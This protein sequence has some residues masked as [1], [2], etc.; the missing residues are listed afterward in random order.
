MHDKHV[1]RQHQLPGNSFELNLVAIENKTK[2]LSVTAPTFG[3]VSHDVVKI[4]TQ[5]LHD[6][7][8]RIEIFAYL[9]H[10]QH[11]K[12]GN[13]LSDIVEILHCSM[14][15]HKAVVIEIADIPRSQ[16]KCGIFGL[17]GH[18]FIHLHPQD[19]QSGYHPEA[20]LLRL[21]VFDRSIEW[22]IVPP[23]GLTAGS[24]PHHRRAARQTV[25]QW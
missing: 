5:D 6:F 2:P 18:L 13:D 1:L 17:M 22:H 15:A 10:G 16:Y 11:I 20:R 21:D 23:L 24:T 7:I 8:K 12:A 3:D 4:V 9:L 19:L 14:T 25:G